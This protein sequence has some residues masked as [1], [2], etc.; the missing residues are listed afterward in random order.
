MADHYVFFAAE[1]NAQSANA[2]LGYLFGLIPQAPDRLIVAI[3]SP[4]G[5]VVSGI[6]LY[7]TMLAL[8]YP[9]IT[10]NIGNVDSIAKR[11]FGRSAEIRTRDPQS[12]RL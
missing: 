4:G 10:H 7:Q 12:P 11:L 6:T 9:I 3:N 1:V 2:F 5:H 8:P